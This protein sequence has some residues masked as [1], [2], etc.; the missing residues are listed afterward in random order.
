MLTFCL[1]VLSPHH[2]SRP[3]GISMWHMFLQTKL[4]ALPGRQLVQTTNNTEIDNATGVQMWPTGPNP[5]W[6]RGC[7]WHHGWAR[8]NLWGMLVSQTENKQSGT[9]FRV[10]S[11]IQ[12]KMADS[13]GLLIAHR[14]FSEYRGLQQE[15]KESPLQKQVCLYCHY[16]R[17]P[18]RD[19]SVGR[20]YWEL[21]FFF[22]LNLKLFFSKKLQVPF[23]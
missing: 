2:G 5:S 8:G 21:W 4:S 13:Q 15:R 22:H 6:V 3:V 1:W 9:A 12:G 16:R 19:V 14:K 7:L 11:L 23:A 17:Y 18:S 20:H 10:L